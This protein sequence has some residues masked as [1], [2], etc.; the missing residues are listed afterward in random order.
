MAHGMSLNLVVSLSLLL[1]TIKIK[2]TYDFY[3]GTLFD[4]EMNGVDVQ[5]ID[6]MPK[7]ALI[8]REERDKTGYAIG[9]DWAFYN[10]P[11]PDGADAAIYR[12][13]QENKARSRNKGIDRYTKNGYN[14]AITPIFEREQYRIVLP[15]IC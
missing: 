12:G 6:L 15:Q 14:F 1:I 8:Q 7:D 13:H 5:K 11:L 3:M 9:Q 2:N 4:L 10:Q